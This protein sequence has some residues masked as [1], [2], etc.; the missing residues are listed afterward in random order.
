MNNTLH[1]PENRALPGRTKPVFAYC[2][3][4]D[5]AFAASERIMKPLSGLNISKLLSGW[6]ESQLSNEEINLKST[7]LACKQIFWREYF[8]S[9]LHVASNGQQALA[10]KHSFTCMDVLALRTHF[11]SA[12]KVLAASTLLAKSGG[13]L[14]V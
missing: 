9:L 7:L 6:S 11:A 14:S 5:D 2:F 10:Y 3:V 8:Y 13:T 1:L 12:S 4:A